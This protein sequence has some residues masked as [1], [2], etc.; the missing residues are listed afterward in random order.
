MLLE[1]LCEA[2][3][4]AE[5]DALAE[6]HRL[7]DCEVFRLVEALAEALCEALSEAV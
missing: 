4:D 5:E 7:T 1:A 2:L 3:I 6:R